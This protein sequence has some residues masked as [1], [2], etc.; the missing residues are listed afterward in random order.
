[1]N[2]SNK[3]T[4][5]IGWK[6]L[7]LAIAI[8]LWFTVINTEN[9]L[10]TRSYSATIQI[11]NQESLFERGYVVVNDDEI[12]S[13]RITVRLRGQRLALDTLSQSSTK[14]QAI[15]DLDNV[16]YSYNG[17]PVSVPVNIV[18]PSIVN[19]SFEILSKSVQNVMV[20]IQPYINE[21]FTV[22][23]VVNY[24]D[25][26]VR[27]L[28]NAVAS[29]ST[30]TA[31]GAKSIINSIA[32]VR[33]EVTPEKLEN[34]TVIT[35]VPVAYDAEGN[36]V[37]KVT[38][39][40]KELSVKISMDNLKS[41]RV[42]ADITGRAAAGYEVT[43]VSISPD[44]ID[45]AGSSDE[46]AGIGV[47]RLPDV[48]VNGAQEN[49]TQEYNIQDYL[50]EGVR[51][52]GG[53]SA[54]KTVTVTVNVEQEEE[55]ELT[56]PSESITDNSTTPEGLFAEINSGDI[57]ITVRGA[58][59]A[60]ETI[61]ADDIKASVDLTDYEAGTYEDVPLIFALPEGI[62]MVSEGASVTVTIS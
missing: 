53:D 2:S 35:A 5:D 10:E 40:S 46:L 9:P 59:S 45:V 3:F 48:D 27:E 13:T 18:I 8:G 1:M 58:S 39:S 15:V 12:S 56:I 49:I 60:V 19:N 16:I 28:I 23:P 38:F 21:D 6:L 26:S 52:V 34:D 57:N 22:K 30:I 32:E 24:S 17:E 50:P 31:Y 55:K 54:V 20:D 4:K 14:V 43:D 62:T 44:Y 36:V 33:V 51:T 42:A 11:Q 61:S 7:S 47:I 41:V 25:A 37:N 29:P